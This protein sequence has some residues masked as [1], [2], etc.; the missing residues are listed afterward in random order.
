MLM[1]EQPAELTPDEAHFANQDEYEPHVRPRSDA[2]WLHD[3]GVPVFPIKRGTKVPACESWKA[4][5]CTRRLAA[6]FV[7]YALWL[8]GLLVVDADSAAAAAWMEANLPPTPFRV[9]TGPY[10]D[11][12][13]GRGEHWYYRRPLPLPPFI[14]R[15]GLT[16]ESKNGDFYVLGPGSRHPSGANYTPTDWSWQWADIPLFPAAFVFDDGSSGQRPAD[17]VAGERFEFPAI[18]RAGER[19]RMLFRQVRSWRYVFTREEVREFIHLMNLAHCQPPLVEDNN[20]DHW[21]SRVWNQKDRPLPP[22]ATAPQV[23]GYDGRLLRRLGL[24]L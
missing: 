23:Q 13:V 16:I 21:F 2:L 20:F 10:H 12:T 8:V 11:G 1:D 17:T 15:D 3:H 6:S 4:Y 24:R 7:S 19:H 22:S 5:H 14:H 9:H 18:V